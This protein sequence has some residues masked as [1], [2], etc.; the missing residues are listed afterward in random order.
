MWPHHSPVQSKARGDRGAAL[1]STPGE[2]THPGAEQKPL[3]AAS[4]LYS[5]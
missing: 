5:H 2:F 3:V 4:R 1:K